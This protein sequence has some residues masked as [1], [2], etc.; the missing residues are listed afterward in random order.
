MI[1]AIHTDKQPCKWAI[2]WNTSR[3]FPDPDHGG[4]F[5]FADYKIWV[6]NAPN[7]LIAWKPSK[8]HGTSLQ[9]VEPM[10]K[11]TDFQQMGL[12]I[13]TLNQLPAAWRKYLANEMTESEVVQHLAKDEELESDILYRN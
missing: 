3:L 11:A 8:F 4:N 9:K 6:Q 7:T 13:L 2:S 1:R 5:F 10:L 12:A